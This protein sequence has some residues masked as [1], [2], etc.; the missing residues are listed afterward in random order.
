MLLQAGHTYCTIHRR[1]D[2]VV[3]PG[4]P[5]DS[6]RSISLQ[7]IQSMNVATAIFGARI[8]LTVLCQLFSYDASP[9]NIAGNFLDACFNAPLLSNLTVHLGSNLSRSHVLWLISEFDFPFLACQKA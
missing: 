2:C 4:S 5:S 6:N 8:T 9:L 3:H 1:L 7:C